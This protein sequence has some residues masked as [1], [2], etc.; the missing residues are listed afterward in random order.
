MHGRPGRLI[1]P[2]LAAAT[3]AVC[4][5]LVAAC[6]GTTDADV[7]TA[8]GSS[9]TTVAG[10][11]TKGPTTTGLPQTTIPP[12]GSTG[13]GQPVTLAFGG[14]VNYDGT[15]LDTLRQSPGT[16]LAGVK[17][18]IDGADLTVVNLETSIA[19]S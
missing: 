14:D 4:L 3:V 1:G 10:G 15:L 8:G 16:M 6:A 18:V 11:A 5:L 9:S 12:P 17:S 7:T 13:N 2:T 19:V